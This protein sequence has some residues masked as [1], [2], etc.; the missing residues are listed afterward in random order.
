[1]HRQGKRSIVRIGLLSIDLHASPSQVHEGISSSVT[2]SKGLIEESFNY[3]HGSSCPLPFLKVDLFPISPFSV[4]K[5][6]TIFAAPPRFPFKIVV[7]F[8]CTLVSPSL[9]FKFLPQKHCLSAH[10][11]TGRPAGRSA[12]LLHLTPIASPFALSL[13][14][15][16][17][18]SSPQ[19]IVADLRP[20]DRWPS[21]AAPSAR[22]L[23]VRPG[24]G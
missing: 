9:G 7:V 16:A 12:F 24:M 21:L 20:N 19:R 18:S 3:L 8:L 4:L 17:A 15:R 2:A 22:L 10:A 13:T 6:W 14:S 11:I 1:M 5:S 23:Q